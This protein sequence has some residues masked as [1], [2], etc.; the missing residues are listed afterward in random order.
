M[1]W[2]CFQKVIAILI[3]CIIFSISFSLSLFFIVSGKC[4]TRSSGCK[5]CLIK[6]K[7]KGEKSFLG[8]FFQALPIP[9]LFF[10][11]KPKPPDPSMHKSIEKV[12]IIWF[13]R[14]VAFHLKGQLV[15]ISVLPLIMD[16]V[17]TYCY[18]L[19]SCPSHDGTKSG[20]LFQIHSF[21]KMRGTWKISHVEMLLQ[22][23]TVIQMFSW[24]IVFHFYL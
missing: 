17:A 21:S 19:I 10:K 3:T 14:V 2:C 24:Q 23:S 13:F 11:T 8:I 18:V 22:S 9:H 20:D 7:K 12:R 15:N 4:I 6:N 16:W 1:L 5:Q